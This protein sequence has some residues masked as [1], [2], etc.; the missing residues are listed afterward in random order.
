MDL[1][2]NYSDVAV[3]IWKRFDI[4]SRHR[5]YCTILAMNGILY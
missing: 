4:K 5:S 2:M 1:G 3:S